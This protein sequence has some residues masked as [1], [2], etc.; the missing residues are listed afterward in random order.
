MK[1]RLTFHSRMHFPIQG[2]GLPTVSFLTNLAVDSKSVS[3]ILTVKDSDCA[4]SRDT[5]GPEVSESLGSQGR[6]AGEG[7]P[8]GG[9]LGSESLRRWL[10]AYCF[11]TALKSD[12]VLA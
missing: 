11:L 9:G 2:I 3:I 8:E 5:S 6:R 12:S 1:E 10:L 7:T 4:R